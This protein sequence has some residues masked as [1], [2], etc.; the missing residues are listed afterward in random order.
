MAIASRLRHALARRRWLYRTLVLSLVG[1]SLW[2]VTTLAASV[3]AERARWGDTVEVLIATAELE[4]GATLQS[5]VATMQYPHALVPDRALPPDAVDGATIARRRVAAGAV[6]SDLDIA[7][8]GAPQA[9]L[10]PDQFAVAVT[11][12]I[13]SGARVGDSVMVATEG[14]LLASDATVVGTTEHG[15]LVAVGSSEAPMV[16]AAAVAS[17]GVSLLLTP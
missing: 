1:C 5:L 9:L 10:T 4:P 7:A 17:G 14:V 2:A 8:S 16:A 11:E 15:L 12:R 13:A 3:E 6:V